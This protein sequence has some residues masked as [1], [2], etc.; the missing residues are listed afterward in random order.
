MNIYSENGF[1]LIKNKANLNLLGL[2]VLGKSTIT[3]NRK[4]GERLGEYTGSEKV[5]ICIA[6]KCCILLIPMV[7]MSKSGENCGVHRY[8]KAFKNWRPDEENLN[9]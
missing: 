9:S 2:P 6:E 7:I 1:Y 4:Q 8:S 3:H 5:Q